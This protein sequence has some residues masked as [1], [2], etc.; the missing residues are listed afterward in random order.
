[1]VYGDFSVL[2]FYVFWVIFGSRWCG[3]VEECEIMGVLCFIFWI[4][5]LV[6]VVKYFFIVFCVYDNGEGI[7]VFF[8]VFL[9]FYF[10]NLYLCV[11]NIVNDCL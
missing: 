6:F 1:M 3:D 7:V 2:F 4:L 10:K 8:F 11:K 9:V 5:I